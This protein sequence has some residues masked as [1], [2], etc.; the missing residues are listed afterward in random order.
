MSLPQES[1][2]ATVGVGA[3][4][5][6]KRARGADYG[7]CILQAK[8]D[9]DEHDA[10]DPLGD[11]LDGGLKP[12]KIEDEKKKKKNRNRNSSAA[13][14]GRADQTVPPAA[15]QGRGGEE[16]SSKKLKRAAAVE[17]AS[18]GMSLAQRKHWMREQSATGCFE[19]DGSRRDGDVRVP[20]AAPKVYAYRD[21]GVPNAEKIGGGGGGA[22]GGGIGGATAADGPRPPSA[23]V[24]G[25]R[26]FSSSGASASPRLAAI[27]NGALHRCASDLSSS[28]RRS[29][30]RE[31][32]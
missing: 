26:P 22:G 8:C 25:P 24:A 16:G 31:A 20:V 18:H 21:V 29:H 15:V 27:A 3:V 4:G 13:T 30:G 23:V 1:K 14:A 6:S 17:P 28:R 32:W 2:E 19:E 5:W 7:V 10:A 11:L 12:E 9:T